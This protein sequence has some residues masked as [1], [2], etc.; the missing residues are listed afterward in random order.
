LGENC[1]KFLVH[2]GAKKFNYEGEWDLINI[3][4]CIEK[5]G[6]GRRRIYDIINILESFKMIKRLK[7]NEYAIKAATFIKDMIQDIEVSFF[8][9]SRIFA[10]SAI[11][12][13][14]NLL[15]FLWKFEQR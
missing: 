10:E 2:Y 11:N 8:T 1:K 14:L 9:F 3:D 6:I 7:K 4:E 5:L 15:E 13:F 12:L